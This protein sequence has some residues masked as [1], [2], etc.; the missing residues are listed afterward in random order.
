MKQ[1]KFL[2]IWAIIHSIALFVNLANIRGTIVERSTLFSNDAKYVYLFT[3]LTYEDKFWPFTPFYEKT[4]KHPEHTNNTVTITCFNGIFNSYGIS[5]FI[6]YIVSSI[7][8]VFLPKLW[9]DDKVE[10]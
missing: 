7:V 6:F 2:A 10:I 4:I 9:A 5:E 3:D 1:K 8:I